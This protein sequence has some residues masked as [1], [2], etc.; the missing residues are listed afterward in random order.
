ME[1]ALYIDGRDAYRYYGVFI[2]DGGYKNIVR[3]PPL[4]KVDANRWQEYDGEDADLTAVFLD[5]QE[6][7]IPFAAQGK[8]GADVFIN[9]L[10]QTA[11]H[12]FDFRGIGRGFKLRMTSQGNIRME[13]GLCLF[14]LTF[15]NDA[16]LPKGYEYQEPQSALLPVQ[17]Y[18]LDEV[19]F[20]RYGIAVLQGT[21][22]EIC[23]M[24][25]VKP[26]LL[27]S[28]EAADGAEYHNG[29]VTFAP[30][31]ASLRLLMIAGGLGEFWRNYDAFL[32]NL[33]RSG[34][35]E[36][37]VYAVYDVFECYYKSCSVKDFAVQGGAVWFEFD[38]TLTFTA[39]RVT[40][41]DILL[42]A[43]DGARVRSQDG[44]FCFDMKSDWERMYED[45]LFSE[46]GRAVVTEDGRVI[47]MTKEFV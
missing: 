32:Y 31:E 41:G 14:D 9:V 25:Q 28:S 24:P 16:P 10:S 44:R 18:E 21:L 4:K 7:T 12:W 19:D 20:G 13:R 30:K 34:L 22:A 47:T 23:K 43:E 36:L 6:V 27:Y 42:A 38:L 17:G 39:F 37:S 35:R 2:T 45:L 46:D 33:T 26:N 29:Y 40:D 8:A 15:A 5:T 1:G 11:Y 3:L